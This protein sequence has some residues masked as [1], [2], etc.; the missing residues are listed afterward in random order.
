MTFNDP[1][2]VARCVLRREQKFSS[3]MLK[4]DDA[5]KTCPKCFK[6]FKRSRD[7]SGN[8]CTRRCIPTPLNL[9]KRHW[10]ERNMRMIHGHE[11]IDSFVM[12]RKN[13]SGKKQMFPIEEKMTDIETQIRWFPFNKENFQ[14]Y[15]PAFQQ[16]YYI[17]L[18]VSMLNL[19]ERL[20][21]WAIRKLTTGV[22]KFGE[23]KIDI[24]KS[25]MLHIYF[26]EAQSAAKFHGSEERPFHHFENVI[27][28]FD[29]TTRKLWIL[30]KQL[31]DIREILAAVILTRSIFISGELC[32]SFL[33]AVTNDRTLLRDKG[34]LISMVPP[35]APNAYSPFGQSKF[36]RERCVAIIEN[37]TEMLDTSPKK[38]RWVPQYFQAITGH[39]ADSDKLQFVIMQ[40]YM[41]LWYILPGIQR[42]ELRKNYRMFRTRGDGC[43]TP[44]LKGLL[45]LQELVQKNT[46]IKQAHK[47]MDMKL[48]R[49]WFFNVEH[50][51]C[52]IRKAMKRYNSID[53]FKGERIE[54]I[55]REIIE[56]RYPEDAN[57]TREYML[58]HTLINAK[59]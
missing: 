44:H 11:K 20:R 46:A 32:L 8:T 54:K 48:G 27:R 16:F 52:G 42:E 49:Y 7:E 19:G 9:E 26:D 43:W 25:E 23:K 59:S 35:S 10:S 31:T 1:L 34:R 45:E 5:S 22:A 40:F 41:D 12:K 17:R 21:K 28:A 4:N 33:S 57:K 47:M 55:T 36:T 14:E 2:K 39:K 15:V 6:R 58:M 29:N 13:A 37:T 53:A 50:P 18:L 38:L 3:K 24:S 56:K 51:D 30:C